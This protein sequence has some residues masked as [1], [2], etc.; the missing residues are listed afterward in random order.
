M[1][2]LLEQKVD[3]F[4]K[5]NQDNIINDIIRMCSIEAVRSEA[6]EGEPFGKNCADAL[7]LA[8][9]I[10]KEMGFD[11]LCRVDRGYS[12]VSYGDGDKTIGFLGHTDVVPA[13]DGWTMCKPFEPKVVDGRLYGRG[14][15]DDKAGVVAGYY[16]MKA[17]RDLG[18]P[19]KSKLI[20]VVGNCEETGMEDMEN[21]S[22]DQPAPDICLVI[23][24]NFPVCYGEKDISYVHF[25]AKDSFE[26]IISIEGGSVINA[27]PS[28]AA[29]KIE[30]SKDLAS[31]LED[32]CQNNDGLTLN[33]EGDTITLSAAG[34]SSHASS[35]HKGKNA[36]GSLI[37]A[38]QSCSALCE[39]DRNILKV[40]HNCLADCYGEGLE[41]AYSDEK[42]GK[43]IVSL[44]LMIYKL[45]VVFKV[46]TLVFLNSSV[47][48]ARGC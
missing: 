40:C 30:Y 15:M 21:F 48:R 36:L 22:S 12:V 29:A 20:T 5:E 33:I 4:L 44:E 16:V 31:E 45:C 9:D 26:Q 17:V 38:L 24:G 3:A 10:G 8:T 32:I 35:P 23:D 28:S 41:I 42:M 19:V 18:L 34:L 39:N 13:G 1:D 47:G 37:S 2:K 43:T 46:Q 7:R 6:R 25:T 11:T 27:V 14:A